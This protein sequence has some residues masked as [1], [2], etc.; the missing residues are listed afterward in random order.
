MSTIQKV[1]SLAV[2]VAALSLVA[3]V[4]AFGGASSTDATTV[5]VTA[6]KP[7]EL[8]FTLSKKAVA[9]G[10]TTFR[11]TNKGAVSHDFKIA[12]KRTPMLKSGKSASLTVTFKKAGKFAYLCTVPGHAAAGMKGTLTVK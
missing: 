1:M 4:S 6:G 7:S 5:A 2:L 3:A 12:G 11:V 9:K 8:R 10:A